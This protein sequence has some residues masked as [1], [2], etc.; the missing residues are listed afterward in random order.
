MV[1]FDDMLE[2]NLG[3][4]FPLRLAPIDLYFQ[5]MDRPSYPMTF[6]SHLYLT[7]QL[8]RDAFQ[9]A[10]E[11]AIRVHPLLATLIGKARKN[12]TCWLENPNNKPHVE[13]LAENEPF[14]FNQGEAFD[15]TKEPGLRLWVR[16]GRD[17][18]EIAGEFH[19]ACTDGTGAHRFWGSLL[20]GYG[21]RTATSEERPTLAT[22]DPQLLRIRRRKL[23]QDFNHA[24]FLSL[25][26]RALGYWW[27]SY[28]KKAMPLALSGRIPEGEESS[29]SFPGVMTHVFTRP[30]HKKLREAASRQS[31]MMNDL[32]T[33]ELFVALS[34]WNARYGKQRPSDRL[35]ILMPTDL[36]DQN[37]FSMP[38]ANMT[39]TTFLTRRADQCEQTDLIANVRD[40][41]LKI[42]HRQEGKL[43]I[44]TLM[45]ADHLHRGLL[46]FLLKQR[47][48]LATV[49]FTNIGDPSRRMLDTFPRHQGKMVCG[50]LTFDRLIGISPLREL[51][52]AAVSAITFHREL[53]I[54]VRCDPRWMAIEDTRELLSLYVERIKTHL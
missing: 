1:Y 18:C 30:E 29:D 35:R 12:E 27:S 33:A 36:R 54:N 4:L 22:Y 16:Q 44:D 15:L 38:A 25:A 19:H 2:Q 53:L 49:T 7:G 5:L 21:I 40:Q 24:S 45:A 6:V 17:Q 20:S 26:R 14:V 39:S 37:D 23:A 8:D 52:R 34:Q 48:C 42:K 51:T 32:L 43:L 28:N 10:L 3:R 11:D 13:W 41:T 9:A 31:A 46:P 47:N 50:N